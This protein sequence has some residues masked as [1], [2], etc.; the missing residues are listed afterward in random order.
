LNFLQINRINMLAS[1]DIIQLIPC[2]KCVINK[3]TFILTHL[4]IF[5]I[6]RIASTS[7]LFIAGQ[8]NIRSD[9]NTK[10]IKQVIRI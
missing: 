7:I 6:K 5:C 10:I 1:T 8:Y 9:N 3:M 2:P 4:K